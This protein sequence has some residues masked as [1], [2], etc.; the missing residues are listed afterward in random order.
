M[1]SIIINY[2]VID[3][4]DCVVRF[5]MI[6]ARTLPFSSQRSL[7]MTRHPGAS[8]RGASGRS[9]KHTHITS[10]SRFRAQAARRDVLRMA[11][12]REAYSQKNHLLLGTVL[13]QGQM[14]LKIVLGLSSLSPSISTLNSPLCQRIRWKRKKKRQL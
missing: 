1:G 9:Y 4:I 8:H 2:V 5:L 10:S 7:E 12:F 3:P 13:L 11:T 14:S 6:T